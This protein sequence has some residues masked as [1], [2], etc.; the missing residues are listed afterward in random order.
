MKFENRG[1]STRLRIEHLF[2]QMNYSSINSNRAREI[3]IVDYDLNKTLK[4]GYDSIDLASAAS[5]TRMEFAQAY[6]G[7]GPLYRIFPPHVQLAIQDLGKSGSS[8]AHDGRAV[9]PKYGNRND[10]LCSEFVSWYYHAA[11]VELSVDVYPPWFSSSSR[12]V[13]EDFRDITATQQ[14]HNSFNTVN[15]LYSYHNGR[16]R[17]EN[18]H[19]G[20]AY[21]PKAGDFLEWRKNGEAMHS[22][23]LFDWDDE[24][25]IATVINGPWPVT[26]RT[27][28]I[29]EL[30]ERTEHDGDPVD[31]DFY[32][33][34]VDHGFL[35]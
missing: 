14:M 17:F 2:I 7:Y 26:F 16:K 21:T 33:G 19:G 29:Q 8:G 1:G 30:E 13:V 24:T 5:V 10:L 9:D 31:F 23:M 3:P 34:R 18:T 27:V 28:K 12:I 32:I 4:A 11:G 6:A 22:M 35:F 20:E 15:K 25:K